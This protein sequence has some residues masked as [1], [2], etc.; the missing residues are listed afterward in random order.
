[1]K[2]FKK[3][4]VPTRKALSTRKSLP[5]S[6]AVYVGVPVPAQV[7][8]SSSGPKREL[9]CTEVRLFVAKISKG[10]TV[11]EVVRANLVFGSLGC[12]LFFALFGNTA[13]HY[14]L[15]GVV[16]VLDVMA[17]SSEQA[18]I[19]AVGY[20]A[21]N[22]LFGPV[23]EPKFM[24]RG[25]GLS[26]LVVFLSLVFWG[27]VLGPIGMLLSVVLTMIVKIALESR[28]DT[29]WLGILLGNPENPETPDPDEA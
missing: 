5:W 1:M 4:W 6:G 14:E 20:I 13:L 16:P 29:R 27:W 12:W 21:I 26:T 19:V 23:I 17:E 8:T 22:M 9:P 24:G 18:A 2:L 7:N 15:N 25:L 10:R 28:E 11:R 3:L